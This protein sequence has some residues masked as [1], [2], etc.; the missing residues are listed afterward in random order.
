[1][2]AKI[3]SRRPNWMMW[4]GKNKSPVAPAD[5]R[6]QAGDGTKVLKRDYARVRPEHLYARRSKGCEKLRVGS[7]LGGSRSH[8]RPSEYFSRK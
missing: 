6:R 8:F 4:L 2:I 3:L 5:E 1:M 7:W